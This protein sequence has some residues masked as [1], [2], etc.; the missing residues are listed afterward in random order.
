MKLNLCPDSRAF[1]G[2]EQSLLP[3]L[4]TYSSFLAREYALKCSIIRVFYFFKLTNTS[5]SYI[6]MYVSVMNGD[7]THENNKNRTQHSLKN[8]AFQ[9][10]SCFS[11]ETNLP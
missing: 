4:C 9:H 5:L 10:K 3:D 6:L 7:C 11:Q 1:Y 8:S 2:K